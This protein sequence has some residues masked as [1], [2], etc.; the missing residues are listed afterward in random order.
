MLGNH[1]LLQS[2]SFECIKKNYVFTVVPV[3][4]VVL[5]DLLHFQRPNLKH[6]RR[7]ELVESPE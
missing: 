7:S 2:L 5:L 1:S 6:E 3:E 4:S